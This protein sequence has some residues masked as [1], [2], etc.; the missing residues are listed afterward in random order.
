MGERVE[1]RRA[2]RQGDMAHEGIDVAA[3]NGRNPRYGRGARPRSAGP[4]RPGRASRRS[5]PR[6]RGP[7]GRA[8]DLE[9]LLDE[10]GAAVKQA[11]RAERMPRQGR[12]AR[13]A[14]GDAVGAADH[15]DDR[16]ATGRDSRRGRGE[17]ALEVSSSGWPAFRRQYSAKSCRKTFR[18]D[19]PQH[20]PAA[21]AAKA[22]S[23][24]SAPGIDRRAKERP[25]SVHFART[26]AGLLR[27]HAGRGYAYQRGP[28]HGLGPFQPPSS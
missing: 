3:H 5:R 18:Q 17:A 2:F 10:L 6:S 28:L 20:A 4:S 11:D 26:A 14:D 27:R 21:S 19:H 1:R 8:I 16:A 25:T 12:P 7:A 9:I 13:R 23:S 15:L 24:P 22:K